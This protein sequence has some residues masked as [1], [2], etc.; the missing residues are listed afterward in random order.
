MMRAPI[1]STLFRPVSSI[2]NPRTKYP[3]Q[4]HG[5][6]FRPPV[7]RPFGSLDEIKYLKSLNFI[8]SIGRPPKGG[9]SL[10]DEIPLGGG[11]DTWEKRRVRPYC[12][13]KK[14][15][16]RSNMSF[17]HVSF[18]PEALAENR[19]FF[20]N[21]LPACVWFADFVLKEMLGWL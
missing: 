1:S 17:N 4:F 13:V 18:W 2:Q 9:D 10:L 7:F 16:R 8:L 12:T 15:V 6:G 20:E 14:G 19:V 3:L 11:R 5:D 21:L